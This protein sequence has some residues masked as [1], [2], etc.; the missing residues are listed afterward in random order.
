MIS[1]AG[2]RLLE[3]AEQGYRAAQSRVSPSPRPITPSPPRPAAR[4]H[5]A[6][7][8]RTLLD[9]LRDAGAR[10]R[11]PALRSRRARPGHRPCHRA[12]AR[13]QPARHAAG[14]RRQP[15]LHPWRHGRAR[16]R[17]RH[18]RGDACAGD[19]DAG[20]A[21]AAS[22]CASR[23]DGTL[24]PASR[25][26]DMILLSHRPDRHRRRHAATPSNMPAARSARI[27]DRR[28]ADALQSLDRA[29]R[30]D[31]HDRARRHDLRL[32][33]R[34]A[35]SRRKGALWDQA[36][37]DWR[38]L[39]SDDDA[40]LRSRGRR[41]TS[42]KIAPQITWGTSPRACRSP[43]DRAHPRSGFATPMPA[44]GRRWRRRSTIWACTPG[45]PIAGT[46]SRLGV[47]RLLH[48]QPPVRS[49]RRRRRSR[50]AARSRAHVR[51]WVVPGS[52]NVKRAGRGRRPRPHLPRRRLRMARARLLDVPRRQ[53]RHGA[54]AASARVSTSNRNFVGRQ[55]PG[56]RTHL[57]SPAM[58]AAA[59]HRRPHHRR[60]QAGGAEPWK[61]SPCSTPSP[62][63]CCAQNVDTDIIIRI[64]RLVGDVGAGELGRLRLRALALP[65]RRQRE[66]GLHPATSRAYRGAQILLAGRQF[67]LRPL[68]RGRGVGAGR[69][70]ASAASSRRASATSSSTTA[71]RT[72][73]CR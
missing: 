50:R 10:A 39:P 51:A 52:E 58:A 41:S 54:A 60:A 68:A 67:R 42:P 34:P 4:R 25:A 6:R 22:A 1:A 30:Q 27:D 2:A 19:A 36:L 26:K 59:A 35:L 9:D 33:H 38:T 20:A 48:Q 7:S 73:C 5:L 46:P 31:R 62:R 18:Q 55:G 29:R 3:I 72:A 24:R 32:P 69:A 40:A 66:S 15:H 63:R 61:H 12:G 57:A 45:A 44:S 49:A 53:R 71:S 11:H 8:A 28:P 47:H 16:L 70:W 23:F 14:L 37:A 64:E 43:V 13:P 56:A 21:Q 65:A 17:H